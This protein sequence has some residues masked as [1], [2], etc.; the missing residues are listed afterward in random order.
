METSG[1]WAALPGRRFE[2]QVSH[3][4]DENTVKA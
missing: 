3:E 4:S 1:L 2:T